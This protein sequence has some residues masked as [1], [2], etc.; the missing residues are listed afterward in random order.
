MHWRF[1]V[2]K[3]PLG[4][5][6]GWFCLQCT[7]SK[8]TRNLYFAR[9]GHLES[10]HQRHWQKDEHEICDHVLRSVYDEPGG[11]IDA[12]QFDCVVPD[13]LQGQ[14]SENHQKVCCYAHAYNHASD[15]PKGDV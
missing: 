11:D 2:S 12:S 6:G 8:D 1:N 10:P 13:A 15:D 5:D 3:G 14:A 7:K 4:S 9:R